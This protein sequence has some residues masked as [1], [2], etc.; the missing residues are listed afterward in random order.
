MIRPFRIRRVPGSTVCVAPDS[1]IEDESFDFDTLIAGAKPKDATAGA[2]GIERGGGTWG[3]R[4][5]NGQVV[6][7]G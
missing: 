7:E 2:R 3:E 6:R 4:P 1:F 5:A